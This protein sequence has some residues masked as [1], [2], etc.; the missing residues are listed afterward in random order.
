M[1]MAQPLR[2][3][4][5]E[6]QLFDLHADLDAKRE[7]FELLA[8][9]VRLARHVFEEA[10]ARV[11]S[12]ETALA[13]RQLSAARRRLHELEAR[14]NAASR[15]IERLVMDQDALMEKLVG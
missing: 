12:S 11:E 1:P 8:A 9:Q 15:E 5:V 14:F 3:A 13:E 4:R 2:Q 7:Q 6:Q 10:S